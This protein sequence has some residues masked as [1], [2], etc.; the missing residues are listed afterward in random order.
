IPGPVQKSRIS[1]RTL[2]VGG[3]VAVIGLGATGAVWQSLLAAPAPTPTPVPMPAPTPTAAPPYI[4]QGHGRYN[5]VYTVAWSPDSKRIASAGSGGTL[6]VWDALD[7]KNAFTYRGHS[8][9]SV[10][11]VVWSPNGKRIASVAG[12][13]LLGDASDGGHPYT[14]TSSYGD[15]SAV[16]WSP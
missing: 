15:V 7:G 3:I 16:A 5:A 1:R 2:F 14:Y 11:A 8:D 4:Y 9:I 12:T 10:N 6:Q 13:V